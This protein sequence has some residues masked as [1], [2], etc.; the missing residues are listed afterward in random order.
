MRKEE[1]RSRIKARKA[2]L[3]DAER[4]SAADAVFAVLENSV[5]FMLA[6]N[7]LLYHSLPDELSTKAFIEKWHDRKNF[8]LPRV[9]GVNLEVLPYNR[10][11][12]RLGAFQIEEPQGDD[13]RDI[14]SIELIVVP[15]VAYDRCGNRVGRGKGFYDRLLASTRATKVGVGYDFQLVDDIDS[16]PHDVVMD[17]VVTEHEIIRVRRR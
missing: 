6:D 15:G 8:F 3:T 11:S 12:L 10:S 14:S 16:E 13:V 7:I 9:H 2:M 4:Q 5:A 1:I 17:L